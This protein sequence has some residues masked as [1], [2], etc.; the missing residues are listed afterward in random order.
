MSTLP[1]RST[2]CRWFPITIVAVLGVNFNHVDAAV[3]LLVAGK[4][5]A[6]VAE[7]RFVTRTKHDSRFCEA[8]IRLV[9]KCPGLLQEIS[10]TLLWRGTL[11]Q[12]DLGRSAIAG[13]GV[14]SLIN[15]DAF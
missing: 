2:S 3:G 6:A 11:E 14:R 9:L 10:R 4:L 12:T 7:E 1:G 15:G 13:V 8:A 5:T